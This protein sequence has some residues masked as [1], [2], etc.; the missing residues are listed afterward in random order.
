MAHAKIKTESAIRN[1]Q[2]RLNAEKKKKIREFERVE[3]RQDIDVCVRELARQKQEKIDRE[4]EAKAQNV[5]NMAAVMSQFGKK[6]RM[7]R[8]EK[9]EDVR[10]MKLKMKMMDDEEKARKQ[11]FND[12]VAKYEKFSTKYQEK[13]AGKENRE[14][15]LKMERIILRDA[16]AKEARD[17][18]REVDDKE[19]VRTS[20]LFLQVENKKMEDAKKKRED[21]LREADFKLAS[22]TR[23][24]GE[25]YTA[26]AWEREHEEKKKG[27]KYAR[28]LMKQR[29]EIQRRVT[30]VEMGTVERIMNKKFLLK[31]QSDPEIVKAIQKKMFE[32]K[33]MKESDKFKYGSSLPG[34]SIPGKEEV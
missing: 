22:A 31:L 29:M 12:R 17:I 21:I 13:G 4:N 30:K 18:K 3:A 20:A 11:A 26:G 1:E 6:E 16:A 10:L 34:F 9:A 19:K 8:E 7:E 28:E 2:C 33:P 24:A 14:K 25:A 32:K 23:Q 15:E 5:E 27:M